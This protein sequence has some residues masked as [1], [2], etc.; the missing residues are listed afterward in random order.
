MG[1]FAFDSTYASIYS[2]TNAL[3]FVGIDIGENLLLEVSRIRYFPY[4]KWSVAAKYLLE[5]K[6]EGSN[7][8]SSWI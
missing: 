1:K 6:F 5:A 7:D 2:S 3:C 4:A 8:N